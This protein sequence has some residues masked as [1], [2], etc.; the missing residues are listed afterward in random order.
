MATHGARGHLAWNL[1][2]IIFFRLIIMF[3]VQ[4]LPLPPQK[5][6]GSTVLVLEKQY[7]CGAT[8]SVLPLRSAHPKTN[9]YFKSIKFVTV[10]HQK[11]PNTISRILPLLYAE[12]N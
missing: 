3:R 11:W 10:A 12:L 1:L 5:T 9:C 2:G 4:P 8:A 7:M 6:S